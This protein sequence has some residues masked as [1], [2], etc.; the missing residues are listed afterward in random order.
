MLQENQHLIYQLVPSADI[1]WEETL[2]IYVNTFSGDIE[3][4]IG[5]F[6]TND[7]ENLTELE[8]QLNNDS[9]LNV[10]SI[11]KC[12]QK[13]QIQLLIRRYEDSLDEN[14]MRSIEVRKFPIQDGLKGIS[15]DLLCI[16]SILEPRFYLVSLIKAYLNAVLDR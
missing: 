7:N 6:E 5:L 14:R 15:D 13:L 9:H 11:K 1:L 8:R 10:N 2:Q 3:C 16:Q 4:R 12:I